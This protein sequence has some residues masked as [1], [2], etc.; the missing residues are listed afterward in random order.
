MSFH[1]SELNIIYDNGKSFLFSLFFS[2]NY[3]FLRLLSSGCGVGIL[4]NEIKSNAQLGE[5][6]EFPFIEDKI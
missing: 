6:A 3:K 1:F 4:P 2:E 5:E